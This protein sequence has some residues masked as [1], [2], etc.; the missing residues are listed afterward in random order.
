MHAER[1]IFGTRDGRATRTRTVA[2]PLAARVLFGTKLT[3]VS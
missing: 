2:T 1:N 3:R